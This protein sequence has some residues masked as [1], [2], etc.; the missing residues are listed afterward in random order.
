MN[1][2]KTMITRGLMGIPIGITIGYLITIFISLGWGE[3]YYSPCV[4][5][6]AEAVGSEI[7]AVILQTVLCAVLGAVFGSASII[8][9]LDEWSIVKQTGIYFL[10]ISV[11]MLPVAYVTHWMEHSVKG[12]LLYFGIFL[13]IG[14]AM[15]ITQYFLWKSRVKKIQEKVSQ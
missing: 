4:P 11:T 6:L 8:W 7:G 10:I 2:K 15:W 3:G 12:F 5:Q 1:R 9:E 13:G 14:I